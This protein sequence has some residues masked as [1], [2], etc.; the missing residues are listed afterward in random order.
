MVS[1]KLETDDL[2]KSQ[3]THQQPEHHVKHG[4]EIDCVA[5]VESFNENQAHLGNIFRNLDISG[6]D[7]DFDDDMSNLEAIIAIG[8]CLHS[9]ETLLDIDVTHRDAC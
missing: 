3:G 2:S 8:E 5:I 6:N 7:L 1:S 9:N 4:H